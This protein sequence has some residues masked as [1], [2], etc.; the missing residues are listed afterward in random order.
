MKA[1]GIRQNHRTNWTEMRTE[2]ELSLA[3]SD[4]QVRC[5][6]LSLKEEIPGEFAPAPPLPL[7]TT[8]T[9]RL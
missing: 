9:A 2:G 4:I 1:A 6:T 8:T 3:L 7:P 5:R